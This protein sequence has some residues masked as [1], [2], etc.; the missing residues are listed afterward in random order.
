M[1]VPRMETVKPEDSISSEVP[2]DPDSSNQSNTR[3]ASLEADEKI[4]L[5]VLLDELA[6]I[7]ESEDGLLIP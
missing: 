6:E 5:E 2:A 4:E 7:I 1:E 3:P